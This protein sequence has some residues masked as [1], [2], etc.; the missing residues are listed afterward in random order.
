MLPSVN[1][2]YDENNFIYQQ[3]NCS[4]HTARTIQQWF[5]RNNIRVYHGRRIPSPDMNPIENVWGWLVK[6]NYKRN[7]RPKNQ[8]ELWEAIETAWEDL[9]LN[10]NICRNLIHSM[11]SRLEKLIEKNGA[12]INY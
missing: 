3:N 1:Q 2:I 5:E 8:E 4:V 10:D 9:D 6:K 12:L 11:P 7:F